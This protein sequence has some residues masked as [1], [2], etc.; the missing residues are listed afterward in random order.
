[1]GPWR[2]FAVFV[3]TI[4]TVAFVAV[5]GVRLLSSSEAPEWPDRVAVIGVDQEAEQPVTYLA[6]ADPM[7][8]AIVEVPVDA[9]VEVPGSGFLRAHNA[10]RIGGR[11]LMRATLERLFAVDVPFTATGQGLAFEPVVA[12]LDR[13]DAPG[14]LR[15]DLREAL[16]EG[17]QRWEARKVRGTARPAPEGIRMLLDRASLA[18]AAAII[19]GFG[20]NVFPP[21][22]DAAAPVA[23]PS[24]PAPPERADPKA[25]TVDVLNGGEVERAARRTADVLKAKGYSIG[26]VED[27]DPQDRE[28]SVVHFNEGREREGRQVAAELGYPAEPLPPAIKSQA[29]VVVV[30]GD[31]AKP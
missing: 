26:K 5:A 18:D 25:V 13:I 17:S 14:S 3:L 22:D 31:D 1:M 30:L 12:S 8:Q 20:T 10:F 23:A 2:R 4:S 19:G 29:P 11:P 24:A 21:D 27:L 15:D 28:R 9:E 6:V 16:E 7:R